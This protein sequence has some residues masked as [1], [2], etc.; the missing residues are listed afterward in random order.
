MPRPLGPDSDLVRSDLEQNVSITTQLLREK[1]RGGPSA[2]RSRTVPARCYLFPFAL[3]T[4][5]RVEVTFQYMARRPPFDG[6]S[7]ARNSDS[8]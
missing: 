5:A 7:C 2:T 8:A 4:Y 1:P 6:E 3:Y